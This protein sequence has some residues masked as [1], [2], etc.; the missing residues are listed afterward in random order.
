MQGVVHNITAVTHWLAT[1]VATPYHSKTVPSP[2]RETNKQSSSLSKWVADSSQLVRLQVQSTRIWLICCWSNL[3]LQE[4]RHFEKNMYSTV[5][6]YN[7]VGDKRLAFDPLSRKITVGEHWVDNV[8][9][10]NCRTKWVACILP[11]PLRICTPSCIMYEECSK[12]RRWLR[13]GGCAIQPAAAIVCFSCVA[14]TIW[15]LYTTTKLLMQHLNAFSF[16]VSSCSNIRCCCCCCWHSCMHASCYCT[17]S[18]WLQVSSWRF[19]QQPYN[20]SKRQV[21]SFQCF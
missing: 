20:I 19:V 4:N 13:T 1:A 3:T 11:I 2:S 21:A 10:T 8:G 14:W 7:I 15:W 17:M 16:R 6:H 5:L 9:Q 18:V 12:I